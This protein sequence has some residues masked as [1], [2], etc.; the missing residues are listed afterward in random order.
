MPNASH[1]QG[2]GL[3]AG[4]CAIFIASL[5]LAAAFSANAIAP[6]SA[7]PDAPSPSSPPWLEQAKAKLPAGLLAGR[8]MALDEAGGIARV[9]VFP[10]GA[11][12]PNAPGSAFNPGQVLEVTLA[13]EGDTL[14]VASTRLRPRQQAETALDDAGAEYEVEVLAKL[15]KVKPE[16]GVTLCQIR[17]WSADPSRKGLAVRAAPSEFAPIVGRLGAPLVTEESGQ[18]SEAGWRAEFDI[19]GY[20]AGWF[21]IARA[22]P[23]GKGYEDPLPRSR[24]RTYSGTGWVKAGDVSAAYANTQMPVQHL[25]LY[26]HV[27]APDLPPGADVASPGGNLSIDGTLERLHACSSNWALTTSRDGRRGWWRGICSNQVTNCS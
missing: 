10:A 4:A 1:T 19:T 21:R 14:A 27:D 12:S 8:V 24:P 20:K 15:A 5:L 18:G 11:D 2:T 22:T 9:A 17:G 25:L 26:P 7:S 13:R 6:A 3:L 16:A 23:P